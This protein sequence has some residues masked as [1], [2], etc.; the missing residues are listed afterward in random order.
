MN[1]LLAAALALCIGCSLAYADAP[2]PPLMAAPLMG[3]DGATPIPNGQ[4][5]T[6]DPTCAKC[7]P[8][9]L[10]DVVEI[11][12]L[13]PLPGDDPDPTAP[14]R[15]APQAPS[16]AQTT[17]G[18]AR[19]ALAVRV[20]NDPNAVLT[21]KERALVVHRIEVMAPGSL[22]AYRAVQLLTPDD[23]DLKAAVGE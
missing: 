19:V 9:T 4:P 2:A 23:A 14:G 7:A 13:K 20:H 6:A 1:R 18:L 12:L 21:V 11:A 17:Q 5:T 10:G 8:L 3:L 22:L 15:G 16:A